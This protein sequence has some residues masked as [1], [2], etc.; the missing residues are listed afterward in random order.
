MPTPIPFCKLVDPI[1]LPTACYSGAITAAIQ[2]LQKLPA[3][4]ITSSSDSSQ[5]KYNPQH[6]QCNA[7]PIAPPHNEKEDSPQQTSPLLLR[8][9][10]W[11][12]TLKEPANQS[13]LH[14]L[15]IALLPSI[16][17]EPV[18][19]NSYYLCVLHANKDAI[20]PYMDKLYMSTVAPE[21]IEP[22]K[23]L[24]QLTK[25]HSTPQQQ[26]IIS[27][28]DI[29]YSY[30]LA[31][32]LDLAE[33][34]TIQKIVGIF[35]ASY[36]KVS[37][38]E[39]YQ[40]INIDNI[41]DQPF[42]R[43]A[44][45]L[46]FFLKSAIQNKRLSN[47]QNANEIN[48]QQPTISQQ[49]D[50]LFAEHVKLD[51]APTASTLSPDQAIHRTPLLDNSHKTVQPVQALT[52]N[53]LLAPKS[54]SPIDLEAQT[55][56][57]TLDKESYFAELLVTTPP[58][59]PLIAI[60]PE[61][62]P[63]YLLGNLILEKDL[64][65]HIAQA[66]SGL[67][68]SLQKTFHKPY[69][70]LSSYSGRLRFGHITPNLGFAHM[71]DTTYE[72]LYNIYDAGWT[73]FEFTLRTLNT[74]NDQ[75]SLPLGVI[76]Y[77]QGRDLLTNALCKY[78][79]ETVLSI[80]EQFLIFMGIL[81]IN[82]AKKN[83]SLQKA[84]DESHEKLRKID[85]ASKYSILTNQINR[86]REGVKYFLSVIDSAIERL[87]SIENPNVLEN[88][89]VQ[90][91][92]IYIP[93]EN[94]TEA[95]PKFI[96]S[97]NLTHFLEKTASLDASPSDYL[98]VPCIIFIPPPNG[99]KLDPRLTRNFSSR[100]ALMVV[101]SICIDDIN[102][103]SSITYTPPISNLPRED[104][105]FLREEVLKKILVFHCPRLID[106][107]LSELDKICEKAS[108]TERQ[109]IQQGYYFIQ[110]IRAAIKLFRYATGNCDSSKVFTI[111]ALKEISDNIR[112][113]DFAKKIN[114]KNYIYLQ[115]IIGDCKGCD[116]TSMCIEHYI[117]TWIVPK[118]MDPTNLGK[119]KWKQ[120][121]ASSPPTPDK[122]QALSH[123]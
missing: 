108:D 66:L 64:I 91:S 96:Y 89:L 58:D 39:F 72:R 6:I 29:S 119:R 100:Q 107:K 94:I 16:N 49:T 71:S 53:L 28:E 80:K 120:T 84:K 43:S 13:T 106:I 81:V 34:D 115:Q 86:T 41:L 8:P 95:L 47:R 73:S 65:D 114:M 85:T 19:I 90:K 3:H 60:C 35:L 26:G 31:L 9:R 20:R 33:L 42:L 97:S 61:G 27:K 54:T 112:N 103:W 122:K 4:S 93:F 21:P 62:R 10:Q 75:L 68:C 24:L 83:L 69:V 38:Q 5:K 92:K 101:V 111:A 110:G 48:Y 17:T 23:L 117:N 30:H 87:K 55:T 12:L 74:I 2:T 59:G 88:Y 15:Y 14:E 11:S 63:S 79:F 70:T 36:L 113:P 121:I 50:R 46:L 18:H 116:Y 76:H 99:E 51:S 40:P 22:D 45:S 118:N 109:A 52:P 102:S 7:Y 77:G 1:Q 78:P 57:F 67:S 104:M 37:P 123:E 82:Q 105:C 98:F 44:A 25:I 32:T 56:S